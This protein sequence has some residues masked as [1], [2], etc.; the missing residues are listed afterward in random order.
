MYQLLSKP[1]GIDPVHVADSE[2]L[3]VTDA[4][5]DSLT[6]W[7][8]V[9]GEVLPA[10]ALSWDVSADARVWTFYLDPSAKYSNGK[11]VTAADFKFAWERLFR[12]R[13][14]WAFALMDVKGFMRIASG[15]STRLSGVVAPDATTLVVT[16]N[17]PF[18]D[19]KAKVGAPMLGPVPRARFSTARRAAA[20]AAN[21]VG[22]GPFKLAKPWNH[23]ATVRLVATPV[24]TYSGVKPYIGGITFKTITD[25][26]V[27]DAR[28]HAGTLDVMSFPFDQMAAAVRDLWLSAN[29]VTA[30]PGQQVIPG[31]DAVTRFVDVNNK[32]PPFDDVR[33]RQAASLAL[34]RDRIIDVGLEPMWQ[35]PHW[36]ASDV[37]P[38][39]IAGFVPGSWVY[40][41]LN[42]AEAESLLSA[43]GHP[44]GA[45]LEPV[46][47]IF[48][49]GQ[50][51]YVREVK[52]EL[53]A[54]GF[55]VTTC[56]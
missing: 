50:G 51:A 17:A 48:F 24:A 16:L 36:P 12:Q 53:T 4:L 44:A 49:P 30:Q 23:R 29:G 56:G 47:L 22:N 46:K 3:R 15:R 39:A 34:D 8:A 1:T 13:S 42:V 37:I 26:A 9:T 52:T 43:A 31:P 41:V 35:A 54:V 55:S 45:G 2:G 32:K 14:P 20:Y 10:A 5:F 27:A 28:F 11:P 21:P 40:N 19:F 7:D 18:A 38:P 25:P 6:R 33:I